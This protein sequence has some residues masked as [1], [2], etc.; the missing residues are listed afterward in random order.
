MGDLHFS[1]KIENVHETR[2]RGTFSTMQ[3]I[4]ILRNLIIVKICILVFKH[5]MFYCYQKMTFE[6]CV[7]WGV[8]KCASGDHSV[9]I[10]TF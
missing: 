7:I 8:C 4:A 3:K 1:E 5:H 10:V 6:F 9:N 2:A